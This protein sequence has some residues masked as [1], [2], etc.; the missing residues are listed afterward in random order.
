ME[1]GQLSERL[2]PELIQFVS[3]GQVALWDQNG[4]IQLKTVKWALLDLDTTEN[5]TSPLQCVHR[6][7]VFYHFRL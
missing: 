1:T 5:Q 2:N 6:I 3:A 4:E 7:F